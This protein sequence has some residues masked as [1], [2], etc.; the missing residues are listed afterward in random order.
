M[1]KVTKEGWVCTDCILYIA[2]G[3]LPTDSTPERD[4]QTQDGVAR[5]AGPKGHVCAAGD[6]AHPSKEFSWRSCDCCD[7]G[8]GGNREFVVVLEP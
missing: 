5:M 3:E 8:K 2:N 1:A 7:D 6:D 4:K